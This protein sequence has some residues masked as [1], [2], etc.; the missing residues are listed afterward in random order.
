MNI[1][2]IIKDA[3]NCYTGVA[4][5]IYVSG[6]Y[7]NCP[8]CHNPELHD[9]DYGNPLN[10]IELYGVL[11]SEY[12]WFDIISVLGGDLLCQDEKEAQEFARTLRCVFPDEELWLF[13]GFELDEVPG[14]AKQYFDVIK[15]GSYRQDLPKG[16]ILASNNQRF[17]YK[18]KD[19]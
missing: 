5:E 1:A 14:W 4:I 18:G 13:T 3:V 15:T 8:G 10:E 9:Y 7:H 17:N 16:E 2:G 19:Y 6:C 12:G 11:E